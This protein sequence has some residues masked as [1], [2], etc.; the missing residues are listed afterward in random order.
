MQTHSRWP[1]RHLQFEATGVAR[2]T[3]PR[4]CKSPSALLTLTMSLFIGNVYQLLLK[5][6][7]GVFCYP[8]AFLP[9]EIQIHEM[10]HAVQRN[11][12]VL[13]LSC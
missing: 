3:L 4:A 9:E 12:R 6:D 1:S 7:A 11:G 5:D 13:P 2:E 8:C 10:I